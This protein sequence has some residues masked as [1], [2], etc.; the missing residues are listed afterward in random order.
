MI[1]IATMRSLWV[2]RAAADAE[3]GGASGIRIKVRVQLPPLC[4][5]YLVVARCS[6][7]HHSGREMSLACVASWRIC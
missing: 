4:S 7:T 6:S 3:K 2:C 1:R 5:F